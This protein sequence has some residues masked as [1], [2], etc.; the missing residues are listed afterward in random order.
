MKTRLFTLTFLLLLCTLLAGMAYGASQ[1]AIV[2]QWSFEEGTGTIVKDTSGNNNDGRNEGAASVKGRVGQAL[3]FDGNDYVE[4]PHQASLSPSTALTI[5]AWINPV[6]NT[7]YQKIISKSLFSHTDYSIFQGGNN[8]IAFSFK[9]GTLVRSLY[10][11]ANSVPQGVWTYVVGTYDGKRVRLYLNGRQ[12]NSFAVSGKINVNAE[13]LRIGG[14]TK[15]NNYKGMIDEVCIYNEALT[16]AEILSRYQAADIAPETVAVTGVSLNKKSMELI[17]GQTEKLAAT[18]V[19]SNATNKNVTW[20]SSN[21]AVATVDTSGNVKAVTAGTAVITVTT[22][23]GTYKETCTVNIA[24]MPDEESEEPV[25]TQTLL[26]FDAGVGHSVRIKNNGTVWLWGNN[27]GDSYTTK[28][29]QMSGLTGVKSL[30]SLDSYTLAVKND[31]TVW[32]W[33]VNTNGQLGDGTRINRKEPVQVKGLTG[34]I[35]VATGVG[36]SLALK[37][38][39]TVWAW[40]YNGYGQLGDGTTTSR[41]NPGQVKGLEGI[42]AIR[43]GRSHCIALKKDGTVWGWGFNGTGHLADGTNINRSLPVQI[44]GL[45][46]IVSITTESCHNFAIKDD[47]TLWAW[48]NNKYGQIGDGTS[49]KSSHKLAVIQLA[50]IQGVVAVAE[51]RY[52]TL[53]LKSDGTVW[54]CGNNS[55]GQLG[56]GTAVSKIKPVQVKGLRNIA[57]ITAGERHCFAVGQ[58][59]TIYGWGANEKG[60][61]GDGTTTTRFT[62]VVINR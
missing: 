15:N 39:G 23:D 5:E 52:H 24:G 20:A 17:E 36:H 19:P 58:D 38:D 57:A 14:E 27:L 30:S 53:M 51:G 1:T 29:H 33:G 35:A 22:E 48:G 55:Y 13:P 44:T 60:Q 62:P 49:G 42:V 9:T 41:N 7:K 46:R 18:V 54:G 8:N 43:S 61:L 32:G 34:I 3:S 4:V 21:T 45:E 6:S 16:A 10:S 28:I 26:N 37:S 40:G 12:V 2:G 31:G 50:D 59:G 47:G 25:I 11:T 56:D